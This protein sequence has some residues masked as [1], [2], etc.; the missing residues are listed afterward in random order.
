MKQLVKGTVSA[1]DGSEGLRE[2]QIHMSGDA[3]RENIEHMEPYGFTSEPFLDEVPDA[4]MGF[5]DDNCQHG[6]VIAVSDRRYRIVNMKQGEVAIYD[7]KGRHV[8]IKRGGIEID[9]V[10]DPITIKT[11]GNVT[12]KAGGTCTIDAPQ[13]IV[14]GNLTVK[15]SITSAG[16]VSGGGISLDG[17]THTG[18][19]GGTTSTPH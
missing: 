11:A 18:D 8:Y 1:A 7:D 16:D 13:A 19:S 5:F 9:G 6:V 2:F 12:I 3:A 17:H 10:S 14:T 4:L 15:G